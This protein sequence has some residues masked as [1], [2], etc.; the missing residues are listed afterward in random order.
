MGR[1]G[2]HGAAGHPESP[3]LLGFSFLTSLLAPGL[4]GGLMRMFWDER[5]GTDMSP[6]FTMCSPSSGVIGILESAG[7]VLRAA[8]CWGAI[9]DFSKSST[10]RNI[11][12][13]ERICAHRVHGTGVARPFPLTASP[14]RLNNSAETP[15][16]KRPVVCPHFRIGPPARLAVFAPCAYAP[17]QLCVEKKAP[18]RAADL[19]MRSHGSWRHAPTPREIAC[20]R[21]TA[22]LGNQPCDWPRSPSLPPHTSDTQ[23][24]NCC[25]CIPSSR[26]L[27]WGGQVGNG[28]TLKHVQTVR[29][30]RHGRTTCGNSHGFRRPDGPLDNRQ[31]A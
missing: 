21:G 29:S 19:T 9:G 4:P 13:Q 17:F 22:R 1:A 5:S 26:R 27:G 30:H 2:R 11:Y 14:H 10:V 20:G 15:C 23:R 12:R 31:H 28:R 7:R 18:S 6:V 3:C 8:K 16:A 24:G 25:V